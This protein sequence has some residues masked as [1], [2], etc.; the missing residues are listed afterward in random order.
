M[1]PIAV[2]ALVALSTALAAP[3]QCITLG[4]IDTFESGTTEGWFAGGG[5][6]GGVPPVPPTVI[7]D[8]GPGGAGDAYLQLSSN[9]SATAGGRL[10]GK[11]ATLL[12]REGGRRALATQ[13]IGG[14]MGIAMILEAA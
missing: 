14:G 8:G 12:K 6:M 10:V 1:R 5:P 11:A 13:C 4:Q 7:G 2:T 3:A 9:G